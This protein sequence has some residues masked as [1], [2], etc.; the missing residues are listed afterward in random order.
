M[1]VCEGGYKNGYV[2]VCGC[3]YMCEGV[4]VWIYV[5][6]CVVFVLK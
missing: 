3:A 4:W 2:S 5:W 6:M 1:Y